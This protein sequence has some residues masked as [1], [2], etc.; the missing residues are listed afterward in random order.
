MFHKEECACSNHI[1]TTS[2]SVAGEIDEVINVQ[3]DGET[4]ENDDESDEDHNTENIKR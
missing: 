4:Q 3:S 1:D 2:H